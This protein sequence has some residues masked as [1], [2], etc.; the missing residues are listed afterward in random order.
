MSSIGSGSFLSQDC[1]QCQLPLLFKYIK[2]E[3]WG[4]L[5][6]VLAKKGAERSIERDASGLSLLGMAFGFEAPLD[7]IQSILE[8]DPAQADSRDFYG[9]S[10]LHVACLNGA[11]VE[12][13]LYLI[14]K[15]RHL[16]SSMDKDR[17]IPL[18]HAVECLCRNEID[19]NQGVQIINALV[20]VHPG[21]IH[22]IDKHGDSPID[23]VQL[24]RISTRS[25]S[26]DASRLAKLYSVL[27]CISV[28]VY[29]LNKAKSEEKGYDGNTK[30]DGG[31]FTISTKG[32]SVASSFVT[33]FTN[34]DTVIGMELSTVEDADIAPVRQQDRNI[35]A[36]N[37]DVNSTTLPVKASLS[38]SGKKAKK[39]L[40]KF[41]KK[42]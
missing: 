37:E 13:V 18:H 22:A 17:R 14:K 12:S 24:A 36:G 9:A 32:S 1:S 20:E 25:E 27:N 30:D 35:S 10:P 8:L 2:R 19:F 21:S 31:R 40:I 38:A 11:S 3:K 39:S 23:L 6:K 16:T 42:K 29:T 41:W 7:I 28:R 15:S 33:N 34:M 26:E 5:R 4:K